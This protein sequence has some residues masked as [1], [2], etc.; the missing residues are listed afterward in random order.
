MQE[1]GTWSTMK[2]VPDSHRFLWTIYLL[3]SPKVLSIKYADSS[4]SKSYND[5]Q[6]LM[7]EH[8]SKGLFKYKK[9]EIRRPGIPVY[10]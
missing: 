7:L 5:F 6:R 10:F 2:N 4:A 3:V 8:S 1:G 9:L